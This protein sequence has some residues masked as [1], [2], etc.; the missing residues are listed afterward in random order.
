[1]PGYLLKWFWYSFTFG[2]RLDHESTIA[3]L[4]RQRGL[5][6][7]EVT[8]SP[9]GPDVTYVV[10]FRGCVHDIGGFIAAVRNLDEYRNH[11]FHA[12]SVPPLA[13]KAASGNGPRIR[14]VRG[15]VDRKAGSAAAFADRVTSVGL[16]V[17]SQSYD[18][19]QH[20]GRLCDVIDLTVDNTD[21]SIGAIRS[22]IIGRGIGADVT[23][24]D[25]P[26][27]PYRS[28][29]E[30]IVAGRIGFAA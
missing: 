20:N 19:G 8:T 13:V 17:I 10:K 27:D 5:S 11:S 23:V 26:F 18:F 6:S 4:A 9:H 7:V 21:E 28:N 1:M 25:V 24:S 29:A 22:R 30:A 12:A 3:D 16:T 14:Y 15:V 2:L